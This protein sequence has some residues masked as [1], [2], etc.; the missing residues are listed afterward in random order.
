[1]SQSSCVY[2]V[3]ARVQKP[4]WAVLGSNQGPR[5]QDFQALMAADIMRGV[6]RVLRK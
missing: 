5:S 1:M 6:G 2:D 4:T 3:G